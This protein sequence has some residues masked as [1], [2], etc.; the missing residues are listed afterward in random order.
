MCAIQYIS[1]LHVPAD[2]EVEW[3]YIGHGQS[4]LKHTYIPLYKWHVCCVNSAPGSEVL[5]FVYDHPSSW[6]ESE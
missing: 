5:V 4:T 3:I 2:I 1:N 6:G